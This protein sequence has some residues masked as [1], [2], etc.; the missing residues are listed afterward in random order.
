M[1]AADLNAA[2]RLQDGGPIGHHQWNG[3]VLVLKDAQYV[4]ERALPVMG[5]TRRHIEHIPRNPCVLE[6]EMKMES[7]R[8]PRPVSSQ[9]VVRRS[10]V[11]WF[12]GSRCSGLCGKSHGCGDLMA[13]VI[14]NDLS[15]VPAPVQIP[16]RLQDGR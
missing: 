1:S 12:R 5:E 14:V 2:L 10:A 9:L 7:Q 15:P 8:H 11:G 16:Q 3:H 4:L 13:D 6:R